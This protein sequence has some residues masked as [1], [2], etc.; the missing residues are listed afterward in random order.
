[1]NNTKELLKSIK[2]KVDLALIIKHYLS[3][4]TNI[5]EYERGV[6]KDIINCRTKAL[7]GHKSGC[8]NP[9]CDHIE[10]FYNS[11]RNRNCPKCQG[12]KKI[13]WLNDR[14]KE[15]LPVDYF[16]VV[17]TIPDRLNDILLYNKSIGYSLL[18][19]AVSYTLK[20]AGLDQKHIGGNIGLISILHTWEQKLN[21]HPHIHCIV[22]G[23]GISSDKS[24]WKNSKNKYLIPVKI[25][26]KIFRARFCK[27][28]EKHY[29]K[30]VFYFSGKTEDLNKED[31]FMDL[32]KQ[33]CK[34]DWVVYAK[35]PFAGAKQVFNYLGCYTYRIGITNYRLVS[36]ENDKVTFKYKDRK[37]NTTK[38]LTLDGLTFVK[39]F[40]LHI[41]PKRFVKIRYYGFLANCIKKKM[42][43]VCRLLIKDQDINV[44][45]L[46]GKKI[47]EMISINLSYLEKKCPVC[48]K[49]RMVIIK[50]I[51]PASSG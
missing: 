46:E 14:L 33:S 24:E 3:M 48:N 23:G 1:M 25:L 16:H 21:F 7:G 40:I 49:G 43:E 28:L 50:D 6:L 44:D 45:A 32:L 20:K 36:F 8:N 5:T 22:P 51:Q 47:D 35:K 31:V 11:C 41:I 18:F 12:I 34:N 15:L 42:I 37:N 26:S 2:P 9:D 4:L 30:E 17:F 39:R 10:I 19:K 27:L 13:K 38:L 29:N